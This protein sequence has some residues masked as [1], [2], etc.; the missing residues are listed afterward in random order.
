MTEPSYHH[1][2]KAPWFLLLS[3]LSGP[4]SPEPHFP[5]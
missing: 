2:Q 1:T 3:P 4:Q 5:D